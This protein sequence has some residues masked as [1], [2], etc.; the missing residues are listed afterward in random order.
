MISTL[1][2]NAAAQSKKET[3][4]LKKVLS[5]IARKDQT[6]AKHLQTFDTLDYTVFSGMQ[7]A[8]FH[9]SHG[10]D[11]KVVWPD[12]HI[13]IGLAKHI[14]DMKALFVYAP[15]TRIKQHPIKFGAGNMTAVTG[16]MEGTFTKPMPIGDGKFIQPTGKKFSLPMATIGIWKDGVMTE[17]HLFW[18]NQT[19]MNQIGLGK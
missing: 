14:E 7:W 19:Y 3:D 16:V 11:I 1:S 18:D 4:S 10:K 5:A 2:I 6:V 17:E 9:E 13:T 12:G 8:R 15:D